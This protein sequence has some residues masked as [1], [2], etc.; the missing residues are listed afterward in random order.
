M[1]IIHSSVLHI[2]IN[3]L[4]TIFINIRLRFQTD[5]YA[6]SPPTLDLVC[7]GKVYWENIFYDTVFQSKCCK[8][9]IWIT[10]ADSISNI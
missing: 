6:S 8:R 7:H 10:A 4:N 1:S 5:I 3:H 9:V 2:V